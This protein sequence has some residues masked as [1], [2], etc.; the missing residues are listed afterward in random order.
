LEIVEVVEVVSVKNIFLFC[1]FALLTFT[2][3]V[4]KRKS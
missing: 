2:Y 4:I 1:S 3:S